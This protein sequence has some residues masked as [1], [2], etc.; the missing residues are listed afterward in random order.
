MYFEKGNEVWK[1]CTAVILLSRFVLNGE[2]GTA[3]LG[4]LPTKAC[5]LFIIVI[6]VIILLFF[7]T[8]TSSV[9]KITETMQKEKKVYWIPKE[10]EETERL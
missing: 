9:V 7:L 1:H 2:W 3:L 8:I 4:I 6:I 10:M 5:R